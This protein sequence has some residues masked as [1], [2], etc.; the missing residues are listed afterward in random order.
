MVRDAFYS[1]PHDTRRLLWRTLRP[2]KFAAA[3]SMRNSEG[4]YSYRSFLDLG[5][6]F[7]HIP[8]T[9]GISISRALFGN[10]AGGH[11]PIRHYQ[12]VFDQAEFDSCFKFTFVRNPWDRLY[13]AYRF[14]SRGGMT[15]EDSEW[16]KRHLAAFDSFDSFVHEGLTM[17]SVVLYPHFRPQVEFIRIPG[18]TRFPVDFVGRFER[19]DRDFAVVRERLGVRAPLL[20]DNKT[21]STGSSFY[22][23]AYSKSAIKRVADI[24]G[25]DV[26]AFGYS[27]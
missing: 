27:F 18:R 19:I 1:L 17:P 24:Y 9:G 16:A 22:R 13:S 5:C 20:H 25:E 8:K 6:I 23:D 21:I 12:I 4:E 3:Q 11:A 26:N 2:G 7:V 14:L 15:T 10:L